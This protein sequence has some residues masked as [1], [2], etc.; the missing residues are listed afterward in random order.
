MMLAD[1]NAALTAPAL[2]MARVATGTPAGICTMDSSEST[3]ESI[4]DCTG[5]PSTGRWV[6]AAHMPGRCAAPPAPAMITRRPRASACSAYWNN[7][8]GVRCAD[9]TV[10]SCGMPSFSSISAVWL[11]VDQSDLEPM[12]TPTSAV[13]VVPLVVRAALQNQT[14]HSRWPGSSQVNQR[15]RWF[16]GAELYRK[17][18]GGA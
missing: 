3:P 16:E 10:T 12:I 7:R 9:T 17:A 1:S 18:M 6:L 14:S 13:I 15:A 8:S 2:P 5:T 11:R 4:D